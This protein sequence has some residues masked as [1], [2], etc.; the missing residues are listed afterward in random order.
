MSAISSLP[1]LGVGVMYNPAL[2]EFLRTDLD[3]IDFLEITSD[4]FW[5]DRGIGA[6]P[7]FEEL[8]SWVD[9]LESTI[10]HRPVIA[11]N[12]GLSVGNAGFFDMDYVAHLA[13]W[14]QRYR[15][16]WQSDHL[17][18]AE[19]SSPDGSGFHAGVA[20]PLPYDRE[21]LDMIVERVDRFQQVV[22]APF[23]I[24]NSVYFVTFRDQEMTEPRFLNELTRRTGCGMLLDVHNL[25][26]NA[27]NHG[28]EARDFLSELDLSAVVETHIAG[29]TEFAGMYTD[30][31]A[32]PC[33]QQVWELL[34]YIVPRA[35]NLRAVTFEFHDS[36]YGVLGADGVRAELHHA[37]SILAAPARASS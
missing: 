18:F 8:E 20:V 11:H 26:A 12:I 34:E 9:V 15:F 32:G 25:Y 33:P 21:V 17:S 31:H 6:Q 22:S 16:P 4:M 3:A 28:F 24:E 35:P 36:Y 37:R 2:P 10:P 29:G 19:V 27:R 1:T 13:R 7:R 5:T 30:S 23:L 14:Q